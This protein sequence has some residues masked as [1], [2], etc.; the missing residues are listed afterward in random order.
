MMLHYDRDGDGQLSQDDFNRMMVPREKPYA[1]LLLS[2][3]SMFVGKQ[4]FGRSSCFYGQTLRDFLD[5]LLA[6]AQ[7]EVRYESLRR[8]LSDNKEYSVSTFFAQ[9]DSLNKGYLEK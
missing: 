8:G 6:L 9:I 1:E 2:R 5:L 7:A 3:K 4:A